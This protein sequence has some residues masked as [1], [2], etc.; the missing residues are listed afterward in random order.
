[1]NSILKSTLLAGVSMLA[2]GGSPAYAACNILQPS[3]CIG[4]QGPVGP[5][6]PA[7]ADGA[8]GLQGI[9]GVA[10]TNGTNGTNGLDGAPGAKGDTGAAGTNGVDG[11]QG[12]QGVAGLKGDKGDTGATGATGAQGIQ[13][14]KGDTGSVDTTHPAT[15]TSGG[16]GAPSTTISGSGLTYGDGKGG[17]ITLGGDPTITVTNGSGSTTTITNGAVTTTDS[18]TSNGTLTVV[19]KSTFGSTGQASIDASGNV[20]T[21]GNI[22][23]LGGVVGASNGVTSAGISGT[24]FATYNGPA[25]PGSGPQTFGVDAATG[26]VGTSGNV[27]VAGKTKTKTLSVTN[28][29]SVGGTLSVGTGAAQT[30][31][32][33]STGV[34]YAPTLATTGYAN[35]G[36]ALT[37]QQGQ[38]NGLNANMNKAF[39]GIAMATA[40]EA[41]QVDPGHHYGFSVN[42]A[43]FNGVG[44]FSGVG[45]IRFDDH[46]SVTGGAAASQSGQFSGKIGAQVQW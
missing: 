39:A 42:A 8:Q 17:S 29:A 25:G 34:L 6:G 7:G 20:T 27:T 35:V 10:G 38:I 37:S 14:V 9:Q 44:G 21:S 28:D 46:F 33:G 31:I 23:S 5:Q 12:I 26:D 15:F 45:K 30:T 32:N 22:V 41:P 4:P 13:G 40:F 16:E 36:A 2:L 43:D 1:M 3:T 18:I 24:G 19:G 11:A